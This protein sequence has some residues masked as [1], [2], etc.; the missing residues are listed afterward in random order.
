MNL[1]SLQRLMRSQIDEFNRN[2]KRFNDGRYVSAWIDEFFCFFL[3]GATPDDY[4]QYAFH[5]RSARER[6]T[7]I[8]H[9]RSKRLIKENGSRAEAIVEKDAF[10]RRFADFLN[11]DWIDLQTATA[12]E[13]KAFLDKHGRAFMKP[14]GGACG[15]GIFVLTREEF[16]NN[17]ADIEAYRNYIAE[18]VL[19]QSPVISKLNPSSV[20]T[21]RV[22]TYKGEILLCALKLGT[23]K[24]IV[25]NQHAKGLNGNV[26]LETGITNTPFLDLEL[27]EYYRHPDTN[28]I[29]LG[30]QVPNWDKLMT[31]VSAAAK[32]IP[33][34]P[35]LGWDVA[36][37]ENDVAII[38]ANEA[39]G[40]DLVQGAPKIGVYGRIREIN[41]RKKTK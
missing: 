28:E 27:N 4:Y 8:T 34:V 12:E 36:I 21:V 11:R 41:R 22:L 15:K 9:R 1:K 17:G 38:E 6:N 29:L 13:F 24:E 39:P 7:F 31:K 33:E 23:G 14:L 2:T 40:H 3:Y 5:K 30:V 26:D 10:N 32:L 25:D 37:L 20:N 16:E 19:V 18:E 35:Y